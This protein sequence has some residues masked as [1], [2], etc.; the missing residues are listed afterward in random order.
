MSNFESHVCEMYTA[1]RIIDSSLRKMEREN[2][3]CFLSEIP[4]SIFFISVIN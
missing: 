3:F 4:Q 2:I 1:F